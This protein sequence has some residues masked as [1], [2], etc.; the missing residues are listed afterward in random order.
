MEEP[1]TAVFVGGP[2]DGE[3]MQVQHLSAQLRC[4]VF[5]PLSSVRGD[6]H[7][8]GIDAP[9][10]FIY[11]RRRVFGMVGLYA[12]ADMSDDELTRTLVCGYAG[13]YP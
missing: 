8:A 7:L 9:G 11:L 5:T 2:K 12:P 3:R 10:D 6:N 1:G 13:L 4:Y